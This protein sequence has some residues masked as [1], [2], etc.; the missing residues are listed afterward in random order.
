MLESLVLISTIPASQTIRFQEVL[1]ADRSRKGE[2]AAKIRLANGCEAPLTLKRALSQTCDPHRAYIYLELGSFED[3]VGRVNQDDFEIPKGQRSSSFFF[4]AAAKIPVDA[5]GVHRY[6]LDRNSDTRADMKS[7]GLSSRALGWIIVRVGLRGNVKVVSVESPF[8]LKSAADADLLCEV[9]D[10]SGLSLLWRCLVP[11]EAGSESRGRQTGIVSV[12]ADIVPFI[13]DGSYRF[14]LAALSRESSFAHEAEVISISDHAFEIATPPPFSPNSFAKGLIG[15]EEIALPSLILPETKG[16]VDIVV[17]YS[18]MVHLTICS[19]RIGSVNFAGVNASVEV[20]EQRML[21]FRSPLVIWNF[22]A[23]PIAVQVRVK[24]NAGTSSTTN[25]GT[26]WDP[27]I[28]GG[29]ILTDWEDLGVLDCGESVNWTGSL[30]SDRVQM[31]AR[32]VGTDGDNSRRF[33]GWS[34]AVNIPA[35]AKSSRKSANSDIAKTFAKMKL[36]DADNVALFL[37]V[38][39]EQGNRNTDGDHSEDEDIRQFSRSF[40]SASRVVSIFVPYWIVDETHQ[41]LEF[42]AGHPVAGQLDGATRADDSDLDRQ[43]FVHTLGLAELMDNSN[44]LHNASRSEFEVL[45]IGEGSSSRLTVRKRLARKGRLIVQRNTSPWSDPIPLQGGQKARHDLSVL[46]PKDVSSSEDLD[47]DD[48]RGFDRLVLRSSLVNAPTRFGGHLGTKL[49]HIV[50]RY[51]ISNETG[52]DIEIVPGTGFGSHLLVRA[53]TRPEPFHFDDSR[54]IRFRFKEFGWT[55]SGLFSVRSNRREVTMRLRHKMKGQTVIVTVEVRSSKKS[56]TNLLVFRQSNHPP[57]RLENHTMFPLHFGQALARLGSEE[58][59]VD[60]LLLQ[61]QNADFAWDEPEL[62]RRALLVRY[63]GS[64]GASDDVTLGRFYL[65]K[66]APGTD[67]KLGNYLFSAEVVADG[68]TRVLRITDA[69]MPRISSFRQDEFDYFHH[70]PEVSKPLTMSLVAKISHGIGISVVDFSPQELLYIR[71]DDV[72][73]ENSLD[74]KKDKVHISIGNIKFNNQLWVTPYPVLLK[75]GRQYDSSSARRRN[76]KHDALTIAWSSSLNTHGGYGNL[77]LLDKIEVSSEPI[78]VNVDGELAELLGRMFRLVGGIGSEGADA[79]PA[80]SRDHELKNV[81]SISGVGEDG[82]D[83]SSVKTG[84]SSQDEFIGDFLTTAAVAAKL[85]SSQ[86]YQQPTTPRTRTYLPGRHLHVTRKRKPEPRSKVGHKFYIEKLKVSAAK[87]DLSWSG[88]LPGVLSSL[89]FRA[90]TFERLPVRLRPF[91]SSHV[92]G[93][94]SDHLETLKAHYLSIWRI[95]D[96]VLGLSSNP[97]FLFRAVLFTFRESCASI[98]GSW[99]ASLESSCAE[100]VKLLPRNSDFQPTYEDSVVDPLRPQHVDQ[101][102]R[103]LVYMWAIAPLLNSTIFVFQNLSMAARWM[104]AQIQYGPR[105]T[106]AN[107][108]GFLRSRNPRLFAHLDGKDLLVEYVE[109][110]NAGKALLSRVRMGLHLGEGYFFH[111]EGAR[112][113]RPLARHRTELDPAPF[114]VMITSERV[115]LLTGKLDGNFCSVVWEAYFM[116]VIHVELMPSDELSTFGF[117][118]IVLWHLSDPKFSEGNFEKTREERYAS[119]VVASGVDVLHSKSI[120]VPRLLG[121]QVLDKMHSVDIR[122]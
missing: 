38:A 117:D 96:L 121:Q 79:L 24:T 20:P 88:P 3:T 59:D 103:S 104:S 112:M 122:L 108:R 21:F 18:E 55:W 60:S 67:L 33:P 84:N 12:P 13:H 109:G 42:F 116:N 7:V 119:G 8:V 65:D 31:R 37:S 17:D 27:L 78:F 80:T 91:S 2:Q 54:P 63:S 69:S 49:I 87:A 32:F 90:L 86:D 114:I 75:M 106:S 95:F 111:A 72:Q 41:D 29:T 39:L 66:L 97:T 92:Y 56:A 102:Q 45:M 50:N 81:L 15:E 14:S 64:S 100:I 47:T 118:E 35:R 26:S 115:L 74:G 57:F 89:L 58:S 25:L 34:S 4:K 28:R 10:Q 16:D 93:N 43:N 113:R 76:R 11:K 73:M 23:L 101:A 85:K 6:P 83:R 22:L 36:S 68:P 5:V 110:E 71:L 53:T 105:N 107:S 82:M 48:P 19:V 44:F 70:T 62:R 99:A 9:R 94:L 61:Y 51:S 46:T 120:Y 1:D 52:R 30:A 98:L 40:S 77:T